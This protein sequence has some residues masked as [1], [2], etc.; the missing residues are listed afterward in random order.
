MSLAA[1]GIGKLVSPCYVTSEKWSAKFSSFC[2]QKAVEE[3]SSGQVEDVD[4]FVGNY[5][6]LRK[7][8]HTRRVKV[9]KLTQQLRE[10]QRRDYLG[11]PS[12]TAPPIP[13]RR[14]PVPPYAAAMSSTS[15]P[16][17]PPVP[18]ST[19]GF[20]QTAPYPPIGATNGWAQ[21]PNGPM[22]VPFMWLQF[23]SCWRTTG[24]DRVLLCGS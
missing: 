11:A 14:S 3:F 5:V 22:P 1:G 9:E 24:L 23:G 2:V 19:P 10:P 7:V 16:A 12:T 4:T 6:E 15:Y 17:Q 20:S 8:V 13:A 21:Y 18:G